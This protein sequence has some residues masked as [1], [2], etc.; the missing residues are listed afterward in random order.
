MSPL[1]AFPDLLSGNCRSLPPLT[2]MLCLRGF[3]VVLPPAGFEA[4]WALLVKTLPDR[5]DSV[6]LFGL[7]VEVEFTLSF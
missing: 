7:A 3:L 5:V 4:R 1:R 2:D 6:N